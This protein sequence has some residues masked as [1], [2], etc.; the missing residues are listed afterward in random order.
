MV[1]EILVD[2]IK[3][4]Q[5]IPE[6][7]ASHL[8]DPKDL[9]EAM[10]ALERQILDNPHGDH[11]AFMD[12]K[13]NVIL[14]AA[15]K[16]W[17]FQACVLEHY[18]DYVVD[19]YV[20]YHNLTPIALN[21]VAE[22]YYRKGKEYTRFERDIVQTA[23]EKASITYIGCGCLFIVGRNNPRLLSMDIAT[24]HAIFTP[25]Q[26]L[27]L[28]LDLDGPIWINEQAQETLAEIL[29]LLTRS[30]VDINAKTHMRNNQNDAGTYT[31]AL[32]WAVRE[33]DTRK[34]HNAKHL[35]GLLIDAGA[36]WKEFAN[37]NTQSGKI[38]MSHPRVRAKLNS[39]KLLNYV[40]EERRSEV[41]QAGEK[42][43]SKPKM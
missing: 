6:T 16:E 12:M 10:D 38:I 30:G 1:Q 9:I 31:S 4:R 11:W 41:S 23:L 2:L 24:N 40:P 15:N 22:Q 39:E 35:I 25:I 7:M 32:G 17:K 19:N 18:L 20:I 26:Y 8:I 21:F 34:E 43:A 28:N 27:V 37:E 29:S 33:L 14:S 5:K 13:T 3:D 36:D 42:P